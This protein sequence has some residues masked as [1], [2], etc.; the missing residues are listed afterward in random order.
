MVNLLPTKVGEIKV[1]KCFRLFI[2][3]PAQPE[4]SADYLVL[5]LPGKVIEQ[6]LDGLQLFRCQFMVVGKDCQL[7]FGQ[8]QFQC[9]SVFLDD[10]EYC[11]IHS[12]APPQS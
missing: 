6:F 3:E 8:I 2:W 10:F 7:L 5:L 9:L 1:I 4:K 11:F 12:T